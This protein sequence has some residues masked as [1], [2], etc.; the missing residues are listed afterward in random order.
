METMTPDCQ[1]CVLCEDVR[2]EV[3]GMQTLVGVVNVVPAPK[4]PVTFFKLCVW[5]RWCG[6]NGH[7]EQKTRIMAPDEERVVG[8]ASIHFQL[9]EVENHATNVH[10][11]GGL[12]VQEYGVHHVEVLLDGAL[13]IRFPF[14]VVRIGNEAQ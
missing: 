1:G 12:Q 11:F 2:Q 3:N 8:E 6:G 7:F 14:S 4:M 5:T 10:A 9:R 13:R